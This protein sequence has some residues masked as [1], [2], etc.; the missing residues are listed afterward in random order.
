VS[1][2]CE[3]E[4]VCP[5][6]DRDAFLRDNA[7]AM[8]AGLEAQVRRQREEL[9]RLNQRNAALTRERDR[10]RAEHEAQRAAWSAHWQGLLKAREGDLR[11][12]NERAVALHAAIAEHH[13]QKADDRCI[14]D[15]DRLYAAAGLPPCDRRVGGKEEMLEN[16]RRFIQNRCQGGGWPS[17][18]QL[19]EACGQ[20]AKAL[21]LFG[22]VMLVPKERR[23]SSMSFEILLTMTYDQVEACHRALVALD[24]LGK[25]PEKALARLRA[26]EAVA[27][28]A[29]AAVGCKNTGDPLGDFTT[30]MEGMNRLAAAVRAW[31]EVDLPHNT[32]NPP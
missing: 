2:N 3:P 10:L 14:E 8:V 4:P 27:E 1:R 12:A 16:C 9:A 21:E 31:R 19:E 28:A 30:M 5:D 25:E 26:L 23:T 20:A 15:D 24:C 22:R 18:R 7:P 32:D 11:A 6:A 13:G 29:E 17:Y